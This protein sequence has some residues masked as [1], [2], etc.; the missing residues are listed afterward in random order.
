[1]T[2]RPDLVLLWPAYTL[3]PLAGL[4]ILFFGVNVRDGAMVVIG[5]GLLAMN[6]LTLINYM[7]FTS[8]AVEGDE[9][10]YRSFFGLQDDRVPIG[11]LQ[12]IDAKRYPGAHGGFSAPHFVARGRDST[13]KVNTKP[14]RLRDFSRL[15]QLV[16][17]ANPRV[18]V[19][20]FWSRVV[21]GEDVSKETTVTARSRW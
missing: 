16:Q 3:F 9:L 10:V 8:L 21:A 6:A 7:S 2:V 17:G 20:P 15:L 5:L 19:D 14:Y 12:R 11:S 13:I 4:S 1:M 18:E